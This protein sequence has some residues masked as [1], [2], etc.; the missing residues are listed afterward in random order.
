MSEKGI[1][2]T[3][4]GVD[5]R[6]V[7]SQDGVEIRSEGKPVTSAVAGIG[8]AYLVLDCSG[9]MG[10]ANKLDPAKE[11]TIRFAKE[12]RKKGYLTGLIKFESFPTHLCEPVQDVSILEN[13]VERIDIG[14][15]TNLADAIHIAVERL[16][17][18]KGSRVIV[19]ATDGMPDSAQKALYEA[20]RA[21]RVGIDIATIGTDDADIGF[22][23]KLASRTTLGIQVSREE[24]GKG[25]SSVATMLPQLGRG[26][27]EG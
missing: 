14:G 24:F 8:Y 3:K 13:E 26:K 4:H 27:R 12:A 25:I 15:G 2:I 7:I 17:A 10:F 1:E 23:K 9:S 5:N 21:K 16:E 18:K 20:Q 19:I 22:L 6:I 11:G